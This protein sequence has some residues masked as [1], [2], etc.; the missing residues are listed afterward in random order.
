M[1]KRK[2]GPGAMVILTGTPPA[3]LCSLNCGYGGIALRR[4]SGNRDG[5]FPAI[6]TVSVQSGG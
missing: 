3:C 5:D 4:L 1:P 2:S 6:V